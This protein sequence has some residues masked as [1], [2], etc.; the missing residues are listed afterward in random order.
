M[1]FWFSPRD[2]HETESQAAGNLCG[3]CGADAAPANFR[4]RITGRKKKHL[5]FDGLGTSV[6]TL[7][8]QRHFGGDTGE[9]ITPKVDT[10]TNVMN[11]GRK[12]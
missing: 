1:D 3:V 9:M 12:T 6:F 2:L 11:V 8:G 10:K 5:R 7:C 4:T